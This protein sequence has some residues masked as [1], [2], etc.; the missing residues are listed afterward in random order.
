V[1]RKEAMAYSRQD[2]ILKYIIE[3]FVI[4]A[5]PVGSNTLLKKYNL[6]YSSAT[7]RNDMAELENE[8]Y[9]EKTHTSSGRIP[10]SKGYKYYAEHIKNNVN[11]TDVDEA[12][13]K[14]FQL[15]LAKKSQS[16]E[17]IMEKSCQVLSDMTSMAAVVLGNRSEDEHLVSLSTVLLSPTTM[18][19][20][21]VTDRGYVENKTFVIANQEE[22]NNISKCL[23]ILNKRLAGTSINQ[24]SEKTLALKPILTSIL[25]KSSNI[26][27]DSL[28]EAF[29][30][31]AKDRVKS[32]G[33]ENLIDLPDYESDSKKLQSI[34][35]L[36]HD[37]LE[38]SNLVNESDE[39]KVSLAFPKDK[40][41]VVV[42]SQDCNIADLP[43]TKL[44]VVGPQRMDYKKIISTLNYIVNE[45]NKYFKEANDDNKNQSSRKKVKDG[46]RSEK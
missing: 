41:D 2:A 44:A 32:Y 24:L 45:L 9:L 25:G 35:D 1:L 30:S 3:E 33:S 14:E 37:P 22:G 8:G 21:M 6:P 7:I 31:F 13:K 42:V 29:V 27:L 5:Q 17:D 23:E 19:S 11:S 36:L 20:I 40:K 34:I 26:V 10:S 12:F 28:I 38:L 4:T 18:T 39:G 16:V 15:V 43:S 46:G